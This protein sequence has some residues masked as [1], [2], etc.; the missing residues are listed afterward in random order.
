MKLKIHEEKK[1]N[2]EN[3]SSMKVYLKKYINSIEQ[4]PTEPPIQLR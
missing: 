3:I 4:Q 1:W 2:L